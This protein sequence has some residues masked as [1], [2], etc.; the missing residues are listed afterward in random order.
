MNKKGFVL[1]ETLVVVIFVLLIFTI[2]YNSA[3]PLLGRYQQFSYYN[4][5][6]TTYDLYHIRKLVEADSNYETIMNTDYAILQCANGTLGNY[7]ECNNLCTALGINFSTDV[8]PDEVIFLKK[9]AI[10]SVKNDSLISN[11][12]KEYISNT[13]L[14]ASSLILQN[15][16]YISFLNIYPPDAPEITFS[17]N[18]TPVSTGY[19]IGAKVKISCTLDSG[20]NTFSTTLNGSPYGI[21]IIN[22]SINRQREITLS[23]SGVAVVTGICLGTNGKEVNKTMTYTVFD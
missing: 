8:N 12:V 20:I 10:N 19:R 16:G 18:G 6:D 15:D 13:D 21:D 1:V 17:V 4:D 9:S 5:L 3:I 23:N 2:L 11:Q 14:P 7:I 22:T